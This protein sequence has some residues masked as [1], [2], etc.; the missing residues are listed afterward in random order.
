MGWRNGVAI[1]EGDGEAALGG[2]IEKET[3][4]QKGQQGPEQP[5]PFPG[6]EDPAPD[7]QHD[8]G[9]RKRQ[10]FERDRQPQRQR[11]AERDPALA[12]FR[13]EHGPQGG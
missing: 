1:V 8:E 7:Q 11:D 3:G 6:L 10:S 5:D 2:E 12:L 9:D 13:P 4:G